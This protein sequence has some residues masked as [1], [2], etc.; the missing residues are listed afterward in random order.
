VFIKALE[1]RIKAGG[2]APDRFEAVVF[3]KQA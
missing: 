3:E 2:E 1:S